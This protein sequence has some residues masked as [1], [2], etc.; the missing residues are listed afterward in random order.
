[1]PRSSRLAV[2]LT[3]LGGVLAAGWALVQLAGVDVPV[4]CAPRRCSSVLAA[5]AD[6][7]DAALRRAG[8]GAALLLLAGV[9]L[10]VAAARRGARRP[11]R[12]GDAERD[13]AGL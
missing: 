3:L 7:R 8:A 11:G 9:L 13:R 4:R 10:A 1:M 2:A 6:D 5:L 12:S